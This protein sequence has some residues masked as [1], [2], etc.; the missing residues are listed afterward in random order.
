MEAWNT[1]AFAVMT[2]VRL[3][4]W[5]CGFLFGN[6]WVSLVLFIGGGAYGV[7]A[8]LLQLAG[9]CAAMVGLLLMWVAENDSAKIAGRTK[10]NP[11]VR[12]DWVKEA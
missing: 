9:L 4:L 11:F 7:Y 10:K 5:L 3:F 12:A 1:F 2:P 6:P 8:H